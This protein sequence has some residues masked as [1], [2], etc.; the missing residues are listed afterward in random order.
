ME[1]KSFMSFLNNKKMKKENLDEPNSIRTF[2]GNYLNVF[3]PDPDKILIEDIAHALSHQCRFSGHLK[4]FYSVAQHSIMCSTFV[5]LENKFAALMHDASEAYLVD[6]PSPI[7]HNLD[8]YREVEHKLMKIIADKFGFIYPLNEEIKK[9]DREM[10][11]LEWEELMINEIKS[12]IIIPLSHKEAKL[13]FLQHFET[14]Q[15][16]KVENEKI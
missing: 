3:M 12:E 14:L 15:P 4:E 1:T 9:V 13:D 10:L 7:K 16:K 11:E 5:S 6:I 8:H 2:S